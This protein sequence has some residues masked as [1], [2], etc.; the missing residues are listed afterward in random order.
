MREIRP[1]GSEGGVPRQRGIPTPIR[2]NHL[3]SLDASRVG[4]VSLFTVHCLLFTF[5]SALWNDAQ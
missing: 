3:A 2:L 1:Y 4:E 5:H